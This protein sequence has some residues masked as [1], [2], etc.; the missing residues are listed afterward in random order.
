MSAC[1]VHKGAA[2][3]DQAKLTWING[4]YLR[5]LPEDQLLS[6]V[7][8]EWVESGKA[9]GTHRC[10]E[11]CKCCTERNVC[12]FAFDW[13]HASCHQPRPAGLRL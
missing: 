12:S 5:D 3:F 8:G 10:L 1:R 11:A 13:A 4:Q 9:P 2:V 6:S 7:S